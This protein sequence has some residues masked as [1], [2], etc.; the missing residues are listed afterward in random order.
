[1]QIFGAD[2]HPS[3][4]ELEVNPVF[5]IKRDFYLVKTSPDFN[6]IVSSINMQ[7]FRVEAKTLS[8]INVP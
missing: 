3:Y 8:G 1:M 5:E 6:I 2:P 4:D 7:L